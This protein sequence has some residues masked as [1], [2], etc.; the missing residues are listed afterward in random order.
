MKKKNKRLRA[1]FY[2][3]WIFLAAAIILLFFFNLHEKLMIAFA[4]DSEAALFESQNSWLPL[5]HAQGYG[6][7]ALRY[8]IENQFF[9]PINLLLL[10]FLIL[11]FWI[12]VRLIIDEKRKLEDARAD[13]RQTEKNLQEEKSKSRSLRISKRQE[14]IQYENT[15][16]QIKSALSDISLQTELMEE[17]RHQKQILLEVERSKHL[18]DAKLTTSIEY[19]QKPF[20]FSLGN[21]KEVAETAAG[22]T[23]EF[24]RCK[25][26]RITQELRPAFFFMDKGLLIEAVETMLVNFIEYS[27]ENSEIKISI[28]RQENQILLAIQGLPEKSPAV[29]SRPIRYQS[30]R[31]G[32]FGIGLDMAYEAVESHFGKVESIQNEDLYT[33]NILFPVNHN[34]EPF[35]IDEEVSN[36]SFV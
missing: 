5:F 26:I 10:F 13:I 17:D 12:S 19:G 14:R 33:V 7:S 30:Q 28:S 34:E 36:R 32:H 2:L 35:L 18:I 20:S 9:S 22:L 31:E 11:T 1:F 8:L 21:L 23:E 6:W 4:P 15:L 25:K 29:F 16:H 24:A 3:S 27:K